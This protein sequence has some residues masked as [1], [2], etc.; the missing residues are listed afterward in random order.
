MSC[1]LLKRVKPQILRCA[2][3]D[4]MLVLRTL[5]HRTRD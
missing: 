3:D 4:I 1:N 5:R 2:Q